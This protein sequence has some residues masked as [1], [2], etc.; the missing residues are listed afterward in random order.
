MSPS[1]ARKGARLYRYY[2]TRLEPGEKKNTVW[3]MPCVE[4][5]PIV[6]NAITGELASLPAANGKDADTLS[7]LI[8]QNDQLMADFPSMSISDKRKLLPE[9]DVKVQVTADTVATDLLLNDHEDRH[10]FN[11]DAK[12][13]SRGIERKPA[14][15]PNQGRQRVRLTPSCSGSSRMPLQHEII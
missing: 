14:I 15:A 7:G 4:I 3:R 5:E 1:L 12:L 10:K 6:M 9:L 13:V 8:G 11:V 2:T